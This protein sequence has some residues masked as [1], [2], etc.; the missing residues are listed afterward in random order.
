MTRRDVVGCTTVMV[1][2]TGLL[3]YR[4]A[5]IEPRIWGAACAA[6][7]P[8]PACS[9]RTGLLWMQY[10]GLWGIGALAFGLWA[11]RGGPFAIQVVAVA[12]GA[13]AVVNYNATYGML[14][15]ALGVWAWIRRDHACGQ[16]PQKRRHGEQQRA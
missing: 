1:V 2:V 14:G 8:P 11:F 16:K 7:A 6:V 10:Q 12:L 3:L 9:V 15:A 4:A 5:F 13:A